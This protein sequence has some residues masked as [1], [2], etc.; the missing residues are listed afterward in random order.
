[1]PSTNGHGPKRAILYARVSTDEQARSGYSLAQQLEA[2]RAHCEREGYEVLEEVSDPGQGGASLERPGMDR[3]RDLVAA[4]GISV[5]L[6]QDRDRFTREPAYHYLLKGEFGEHGTKLRALNDS[7]DESPEGELTDGILDQLAKY[8]RTKFTERSRRGKL[9]KAREGKIV[10]TKMPH[11]GFKL[12]ASRDAYEVDQTTMPVVRRIFHMVGSQGY[13]LHGVKKRFEAQGLLTP[14][15]KRYWSTTFIREVIKDDVY[16]PHTFEE[17]EAL[18]TPGVA[19]RLEPDKS[20][21]ICWF[22][23]QRHTY[24]Q[25]AQDS[26]EGK[27]YRKKKAATDRPRN[28]W[29]AVPVPDAGISRELVDAAKRAIRDNSKPSS[30]GRRAWELSGGVLYCGSCG[31]QMVPH[32][33]KSGGRYLYYYR[34]RRRWHQGRD[35][36]QNSRL[37]RVEDLEALVWEMVSGLLKDP[38]Q[39]RADLDTMIELERRSMRGDPNREQE[40]WLN[41]LAEVDRKRARYQ[42]MAADDLIT[43]DEL[44]SKLA[45]LDDTRSVAERELEALRAHRER[46]VELETDRDALLDSLVGIAPDALDSLA[47][48]E[49][50]HVYKTLKLR[51]VTHKDGSL[52]L[53]GTFEE[54][55]VMCQSGTLR[56]SP[57]SPPSRVLR[58]RSGSTL[59]RLACS[60]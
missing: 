55:P 10:A 24:K 54:S 12:T 37:R 19:A 1:M 29:I 15:G 26:P 25:V 4:G 22:N 46:V 56:P 51:V 16:C 52:D 33:S 6:A 57:Y 48:D 11:Y 38:D 50:H 45:D 40:T 30:A 7:G 32:S 13:S 47:P 31:R 9:R 21:G 35:A 23:R 43:F 53:S 14:A 28:E 60:H 34:C 2:L 58:G 18:V 27:V 39:L 3:V 20:Y 49:R 17:L 41:T 59:S 8:E 42:E 36:C 44:K 5:V